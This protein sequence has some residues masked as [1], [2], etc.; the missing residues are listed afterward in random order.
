MSNCGDDVSMLWSASL[1][2]SIG[3]AL[4]PFLLGLR[5]GQGALGCGAS[6]ALGL[7]VPLLVTLEPFYIGALRPLLDCDSLTR[8]PVIV[9][10]PPALLAVGAIGLLVLMYRN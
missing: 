10:T 8:V 1:F 9:G 5:T 3:V 2:V 4:V 6:V 7:L